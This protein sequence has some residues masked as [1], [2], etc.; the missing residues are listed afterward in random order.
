MKKT[1]CIFCGKYTKFKN[2]KKTNMKK[3]VTLSVKN[4]ENL[5]FL[6]Y[7]IFSIKH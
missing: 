7:H 5:K 2:T 6:K 3:Y 1:Y 4:I